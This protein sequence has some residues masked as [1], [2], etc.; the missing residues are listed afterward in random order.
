MP[1]D[2]LLKGLKLL[3]EL[4]FHSPQCTNEMGMLK[5]ILK[6]DRAG[7]DEISSGCVIVALVLALG[8]PRR[9]D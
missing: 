4:R 6:A 3:L 8:L 2:Y 5:A 1:I 9:T 7:R